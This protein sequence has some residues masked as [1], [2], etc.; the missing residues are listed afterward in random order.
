MANFRNKLSHFLVHGTAVPEVYTSPNQFPRPKYPQRN[1]SEHAAYLLS[2]IHS[3]VNQKTEEYSSLKGAPAPDGIFL[4]FENTPGFDITLKSLDL[5]SQQIELLNVKESGEGEQKKI[6]ATIFVPNEKIKTFVKKIEAYRDES[7][8]SGKPKNNNLVSSIDN[9]RLAVLKSLWTDVEDFFPDAQKPIWWEV[10]LTASPDSVVRFQN[11]AKLHDIA[12]SV[13][14][15]EFPDRHVMLAYVTADVLSK[16]MDYLSFVA[17]V[18]RA[19]ETTDD[20]LQMRNDEQKQWSD[21][22]L[23]LIDAPDEKSNQVIC[24]LDTGVSKQHPLINQFLAE[25]SRHACDD[26]WGVH[27]HRGHGTEMAGLALYGDLS[28]ALLSTDKIKV[29]CRIESVKILPPNGE[30][31][32]D[33]Y[34]N[35]TEVAVKCAHT[36]APA[37]DRIICMAVASTDGRDQGQPSSWSAAIDKISVGQTI[38]GKRH[39]CIIASGNADS[40]NYPNYPITNLTDGIHD[41]AQSW[42]ALTVGSYTEKAHISE[43][44]LSGWLPL[45]EAGGI[46][47]SNTTSLVWHDKKWPIKPDV[48][49]EGGNA[50]IDPTKVNIDTPNSLSLLTTSYSL[51]TN[52]F[53]YTADTS[54][55]TAQIANMAATIGGKYP[56]FWPETIRGIIVHSADWTAGMKKA[57]PNISKQ[58]RALLL[59]IC[60]YGVPSLD[61]ALWSASNSLTLIAQDELKPYDKNSM[62]ELNLH[63]LPWPIDV[64]Q[65]LGETMVK[66]RVTL[67]YFIEP[68]PARRGWEHKFRYQSHGLRFDVKTPTETNQ[69]FLTRMNKKRWDDAEGRASVTS[70]GD[71]SEWF[72]GERLR[73][74]GSVHSDIWEGTA[75]SLAERSQIVVYPVTG[76]WREMHSKGH[77]SKRARYSLIVTISTPELT[78]DIYTPVEVLILNKV[79]VK[80]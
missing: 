38:L 24:I 9:I 70:K 29:P 55:A 71:S 36:K 59:R 49:Y 41:P 5:P 10:W 69:E 62:D 42:N 22:F 23:G 19:K 17:E 30:N 67:S 64:L 53:T 77:T 28:A 16:N 39:L 34:G 76:W 46:A 31:H 50:A 80:T 20:F 44:G 60:G 13:R 47:P 40:R 37:K 27:D 21:S 79:S 33:L 1:R 56:S 57:Y 73:S 48:V 6:T 2:Q 72:F 58:D 15:Q 43:S 75:V 18:R 74:K 78:A 8:P 32:P 25:N 66:M 3:I 52:M 35:I 63:S 14:I 12:L 11:F 4:E 26:S 68:N 51:T 7:T 61:Q 54:A 45:A 65:S